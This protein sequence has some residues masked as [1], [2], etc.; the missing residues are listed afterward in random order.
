MDNFRKFLEDISE[1]TMVFIC[2]GSLQFVG[3]LKWYSQ[4]KYEFIYNS[5]NY[6]YVNLDLNYSNVESVEERKH[7]EFKITLNDGIIFTIRA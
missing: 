5:E 1:G 7:N 3:R 6:Q 2:F 4:G